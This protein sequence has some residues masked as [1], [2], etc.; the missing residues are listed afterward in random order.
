MDPHPALPDAATRVRD[1]FARQRFMAT[2]GATLAEVAPGRVAIDLPF[3][4]AL[5]Q[6]HGFL[7]AGAGAAV[8]D[9][10]CGYAALTLMPADAAVLTIEFKVNLLAPGAGARFRAVGRVVRAG[11]TITVCA[12]ELLALPDEEGA[13][14]VPVAMMQAT[15][16]A[17][18]ERPAL[19]D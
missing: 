3:E 12:G 15:I 18:R 14:P 4:D 16:M 6:Q 19:R 10:A 17:V 7:H 11:R 1:S 8:V 5:A 2:L 13:E 9:S